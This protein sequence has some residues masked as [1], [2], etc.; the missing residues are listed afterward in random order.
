MTGRSIGVRNIVTGIE[1]DG[2]I[3]F[4]NG[5]HKICKSYGLAYMTQK[6][7]NHQK[8]TFLFKKRIA[9]E[10]KRRIRAISRASHR[11]ECGQGLAK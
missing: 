11:M 5:L 2:L 9:F 4:F 7:T 6:T 3:V 10:A 1:R 8:A